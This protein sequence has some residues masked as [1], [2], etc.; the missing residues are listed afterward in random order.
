VGAEPASERALGGIGHPS[1][2]VRIGPRHKSP[3]VVTL[4]QREGDAINNICR[5]QIELR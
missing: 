3:S 1:V 4:G 2:I 5:K